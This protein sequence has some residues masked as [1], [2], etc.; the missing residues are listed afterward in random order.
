MI[1]IKLK[2]YN[3]DT[4]TLKYSVKLKWVVWYR[5]ETLFLHLTLIYNDLRQTGLCSSLL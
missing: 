4:K 1:S 3:K 2:Q 5:S